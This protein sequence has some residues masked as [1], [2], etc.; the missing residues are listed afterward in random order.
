LPDQEN[1]RRL[2]SRD[3]FEGTGV[4]A[5]LHRSWMKSQGLP[6]RVFDGRPV[7]GI[8][9]TW[10]ELTPCNAHFRDLAE[11]VRRGII[12]AGGLPVEFPVTSLG[13]TVVRPTSMLFRNLVSMDVEES[14]RANPLDGVVLLCG[15]DKTTPSL[16]M[17]A[18]SC[19]LP[20]IVVS[21]GP[22]LNGRHEGR[23][24]GSGT[25]VF[26][27]SEEVRAA[28]MT[29]CQFRAV[30]SSMSRSHG[31]CNTMGTASTMASLVEV[32]GLALPGNAAAPA[33][34]ARR[35][36]LARDSGVRIVHMVQEDLRLSHILRRES[37]VNAIRFNAAIGGSTNAVIHLLALAGRMEINLALDDFAAES[38][39]VPL[40]VD[41]MPAGRF[42][43][44]D[45]FHAGGVPAV[46]EE[47]GDM[48]DRSCLTVTGATLGENNRGARNWDA[49][50]IRSVAQPLL[51]DAAI[52]VLRGNLA[53]D[54]AVIKP[55]AASP[56]LLKHVGPA[57]VYDGMEDLLE[58][59]D[60]DP[61]I[62]EDTVLVLR[63]VGPRGYPGMPE[64]GNL[65]LPRHL[66]ARGVRDMVRI[67]DARMSGTAFGTVVLHVA[68]E[69]AVGGPLAA[70]RD[71]DLIELDAEAGS[72]RL[73]VDEGE[74]AARLAA[75][76]GDAA[77][78]AGGYARLFSDHVLQADRGADFDFLVGRRGVELTGD[79][80]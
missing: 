80:H 8:C 16:L 76:P 66:L 30:E 73:L 10:S 55:A 18:A 7:I 19:D 3:W 46:V 33:V 45:F 11:H 28:T 14:I 65:P 62:D 57:R 49:E 70:V 60:T 52:A 59:L 61:D 37:F 78:P 24:V 44:E 29:E 68:P 54:G 39:G 34:D 6:D 26:Q 48:L 21:G 63:G 15:C 22:M 74:I 56:H 31:H 71:G 17:G 23:V 25:S 40:L 77:P 38:R 1:N 27:M 4:N 72:L 36:V 75:Q 41:L 58:R 79:N 13:E 53:P 51:A 69:S 32:M 67:S 5:F 35:Q 20:T 12:E 9:N 50:V 42:L 43:M 64:V 47:L 2:R